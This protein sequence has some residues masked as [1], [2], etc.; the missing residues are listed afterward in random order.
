[1]ALLSAVSCLA[2]TGAAVYVAVRS[3]FKMSG[4]VV[5]IFKVKVCSNCG[6]PR[7]MLGFAT[8]NS[9]RCMACTPLVTAP[10]TK[11]PGRQRLWK[12]QLA[13]INAEL[14]K[15]GIAKP[16][17]AKELLGVSDV[18]ELWRIMQP[19]LL[20]NMTED[21]YG[22]GWHLDH[23]FPVSAFDL[24]QLCHR[25]RCFH[26]TNLKPLWAADNLEKSGCI[27]HGQVM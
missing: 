9:R 13:R 15:S 20:T 22:G 2:V 12:A 8:T 3:H 10:K 21:N 24:S 27:S 4:M 5:P 19:K 11:K 23:I 25:Q 17:A 14:K 26:V 16:G 6:L 18:D 7:D 1:M